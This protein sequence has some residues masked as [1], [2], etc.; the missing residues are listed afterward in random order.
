VIRLAGFSAFGAD[1][2]AFPGGQ[3]CV[4]RNFLRVFQQ[5]KSRLAFGE[6]VWVF[7]MITIGMVRVIVAT[8]R[9][10]QASA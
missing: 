10:Q 5:M 8:I 4:V 9:L 3:F 7:L 6:G 2:T 1:T